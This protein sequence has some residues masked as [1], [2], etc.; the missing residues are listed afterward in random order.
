MAQVD[1]CV[2]TPTP[3]ELAI[4]QALY[5]EQQELK[6][7][8][9]GARDA[10]MSMFSDVTDNFLEMRKLKEQNRHIKVLM[11]VDDDAVCEQWLPA[12]SCDM[13]PLE[14]QVPLPR[15]MKMM[16]AGSRRTAKCLDPDKDRKNDRVFTQSTMSSLHIESSDSESEESS[17]GSSI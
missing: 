4:I 11:G 15:F 5:D 9:Q 8:S 14:T 13:A 16:A 6:M 7:Q 10:Y 2:P 1:V 3:E 17:V 12:P